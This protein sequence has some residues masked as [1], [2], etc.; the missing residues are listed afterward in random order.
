MPRAL[1]RF[2]L[3]LAKD[4]QAALGIARAGETVRAAYPAGSVARR[5]WYQARLEALYELAFLRVFIAWETFLEATFY[6][7]LCGYVSRLGPQTPTVVYR[8]IADA[9]IAVLG[10]SQY[11]AWYKCS[12][13]IRRCQT[14]IPNG[15]H[16]MTI[17]S[18]LTDLEHYSAVRHRIAHG[19]ANAKAKFDLATQH[20]AG[21]TYRG[22]R[23]GRFLREWDGTTWPKKTWLDT[24]VGDLCNLAG[25]IA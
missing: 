12:T 23:P 17:N 18:R 1:P 13:V 22:S 2:D 25:Q 6:R 14:H 10:G 3:E 24:I 20:F 8:S 4:G 21:K 9:E 7:Y 5:E 16:E 11:I 19:Q 15:W